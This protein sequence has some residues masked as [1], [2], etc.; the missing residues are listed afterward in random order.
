[1]KRFLAAEWSSL[2][3]IVALLIMMAMMTII[4]PRFLNFDNQAILTRSLAPL[5]IVAFAQ[6]IVI[7]IGQMNLAVGAIGGMVAVFFG[8]MMQ[9]WGLPIPG[10]RRSWGCCVV[11]AAGL[12]NG[13]DHRL[14]RGSTGF[15]RD[16]GDAVGV[17]GAEPR[18]HQVDP[19]LR[20][21]RMRWSGS[22]RPVSAPSRP[23]LIVPVISVIAV[24]AWFLKMH[25]N[26]GVRSSQSGGNA[27]A[28]GLA[29]HLGQAGS[30]SRPMRFRVRSRG[31]PACSVGG[32]SG[33]RNQPTI[34]GDWLSGE[35]CRPGH[36]GSDPC[37]RTHPHH[38]APSLACWSSS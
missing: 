4:T 33:C 18:G 32:A 24:L 11:S 1:M 36:R 29:G 25:P 34:G 8:G 7:G 6:A 10:R 22:A 35:L 19:V 15:R 2:L 30:P 3:A 14:F 27:H 23:S 31:P 16:A 28:A 9:V 13:V 38:R 37:R 5:L 17:Q 26:W 21:A 20:N 12:L